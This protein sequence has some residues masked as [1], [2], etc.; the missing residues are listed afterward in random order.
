[1]KCNGKKGDL[2][3]YLMSVLPFGGRHPDALDNLK[4]LVP[5]RLGKNQKLHRQLNAGASPI[6][7]IESSGLAVPTTSLPLDGEKLEKL[8]EYIV[9]GLMWYHWGVLLAKDCVV[10]VMTPGS[11]IQKVFD[12]MHRQRAHA[13]LNENLGNGTFVYRATQG[14]D[15]LQVSIWEFSMY[16]C[17]HLADAPAFPGEVLS[18][19]CA[20]T[21]PARIFE[22]ASAA[23]T[24][25]LILR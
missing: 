13:R 12:D 17:M 6:W 16:G 22:S 10:E 20:I 14:V 9:R 2:E 25:D 19:I 4:N 7:S 11:K 15:N 5:P 8:F 21:G 1:M 18:R 24:V 3:T 23:S